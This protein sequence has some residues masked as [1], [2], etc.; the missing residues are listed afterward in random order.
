MRSSAASSSG[1][2][3]DCQARSW[4][5]SN[6]LASSA[7]SSQPGG[8]RHTGC[9]VPAANGVAAL[10]VSPA[11]WLKTTDLPMFVPPTMATISSG[12]PSTCGSSLQRSSSN[13]LGPPAAR[14][15]AA[16]RPPP[17]RQATPTTVQSVRQR[18][19][20]SYVGG[21]RRPERRSEFR[22]HPIELPATT[23]VAVPAYIL[24]YH[25]VSGALPS[26]RPFGTVDAADRP[27][28]AARFGD[29]SCGS[30]P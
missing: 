20:S 21:K 14:H 9:F 17:A 24:R 25:P 22:H 26:R 30:C 7:G 28:A 27:V 15:L 29:R 19:R 12:G 6:S 5:C 3:G 23:L 13:H 11:R 2:S 8:T 16:R 10:A 18:R 1:S 4:K